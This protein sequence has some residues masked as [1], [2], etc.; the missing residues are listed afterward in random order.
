M[1]RIIHRRT[2]G[3]GGPEWHVAEFASEFMVKQT[4][5]VDVE[6][7]KEGCRCE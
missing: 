7:G 6:E 5:M 3:G 1:P 2:N 4:K